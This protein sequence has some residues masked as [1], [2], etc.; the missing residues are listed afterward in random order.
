M[1]EN[2]AQ[3]PGLQVKIAEQV[4]CVAIDL[5]HPAHGEVLLRR[6]RKYARK[7]QNVHPYRFEEAT[8]ET[9]PE[10]SEALERL[11][12][13]RRRQEHCRGALSN[14]LDRSFHR[15][16]ARRFLNARTLMFCG[17]RMAG[18]LVAVIYGFGVCNRVYSYLSGFDTEYARK[19]V[20]AISIGYAVDRA[21]E[22]RYDAFDF[23]QGREPYKY[24]WG[25][26]DIPCLARTIVKA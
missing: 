3:E 14:P 1:L 17:I 22:R 2:F 8:S 10:F 19:S 15:E 16:V 5:H 25:A 6:S 18:K 11:H 24:T 12:Q 4:P 13:Q 23:L 21:M 7:L 9:L 26:R 20:G